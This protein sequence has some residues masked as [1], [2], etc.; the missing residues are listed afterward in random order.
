MTDIANRDDIKLLVDSFYAKIRKDELLSPVFASR[1]ADDAWGKHLTRM[2]SFWNTVLFI[3]QSYKGNPFA[4]HATLPVDDAHFKQWI[5]LFHATVDEHFAGE[6]A[7][8]TKRRAKNMAI[9][10]TAKLQHLRSNPSFQNLV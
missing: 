3:E 10:F 6:K 4:R 1:I 8:E 5:H 7:E 9:M 2:Y